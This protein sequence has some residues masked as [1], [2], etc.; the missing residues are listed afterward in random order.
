[1]GARGCQ[2]LGVAICRIKYKGWVGVSTRI[3]VRIRISNVPRSEIGV[4]VRMDG[5]GSAPG[6]DQGQGRGYMSMVIIILRARVRD[7]VMLK[8]RAS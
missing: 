8:G 3:W 7:R 1:M 4:K 2:E 5:R 6:R